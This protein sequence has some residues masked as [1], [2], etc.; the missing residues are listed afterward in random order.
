MFSHVCVPSIWR[1]LVWNLIQVSRFPLLVHCVLGRVQVKKKTLLIFVLSFLVFDHVC[2]LGLRSPTYMAELN[3]FML[4]QCLNVLKFKKKKRNIL[5]LRQFA[6]HDL[7]SF[8][9][10]LIFSW[11]RVGQT[12]IIDFPAVCL[13]FSFR[14]CALAKQALNK[15]QKFWN[16]S[17]IILKLFVGCSHVF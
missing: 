10:P 17:K 14:F 2:G 15:F 13:F 8:F 6:K 7:N 4:R 9:K 1:N 5:F 3:L 16:I 12:H 11:R